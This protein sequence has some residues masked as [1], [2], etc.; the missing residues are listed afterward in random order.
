M[1]ES[2]AKC[3]HRILDADEIV[4]LNER[5]ETA[6]PVEIVRWAV[7]RFPGKLALSVS[8]GGDGGTM[9]AHMIAQV[10]PVVDVL[11]LDTEL[12]FKETYEFR[13]ALAQRLRLNVVDI[14]PQLTVHE[15]ELIHGATL[16]E[17][18]PDQCCEMRKVDPMRKAFASYDCWITGIR[19]SQS[20]TRANA[21]VVSY[22]SAF[23]VIKICPLASADETQIREYIKSHNLP[24]NPLQD[25]GYSSIGCWP[26]TSKTLTGEDPRAG[27]WRQSQKTECGLHTQGIAQRS[28]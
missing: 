25:Q 7:E 22:D 10:Q 24:H 15:Q 14:H 20:A 21:P 8:F 13:T 26:C 11:F 19:R 2:S 1:I 28:S 27:R 23:D 4:R 9:L 18:A 3:A 17:Q 5:F 12:L 16:W 6:S